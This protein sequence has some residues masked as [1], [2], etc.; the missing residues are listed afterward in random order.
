MISYSMVCR[1]LISY[2]KVEI[3]FI[4]AG[5]IENAKLVLQRCLDNNAAY[6]NAHILMAQVRQNI[7]VKFLHNKTYL[8]L[9][10]GNPERKTFGRWRLGLFEISRICRG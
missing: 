3:I 2:F 9:Q 7:L 4:F 6:V 10:I 5:D 8:V 1:P